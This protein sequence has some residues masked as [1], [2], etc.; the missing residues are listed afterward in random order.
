[1][2]EETR[3][4]LDRQIWLRRLRWVGIGV[5]IASV[6]A[7]LAVFTGLDAEVKNK[8]LPGIVTA[9]GPIAGKETSRGYTVDVELEDSHRT[10]QVLVLKTR[11]PYVGEHVEITEHDHGSGRVTFSWK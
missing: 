5:A 7:A 10:V 1:M 8:R 4:K 9:I 11:N 2:R 6:A 3:Q